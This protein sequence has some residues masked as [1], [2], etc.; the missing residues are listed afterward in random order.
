MIELPGEEDVGSTFTSVGGGG[1]VGVTVIGV[2]V[3]QAV[4]M[5]NANKLLNRELGNFFMGSNWTP[6]NFN[7]QD[8][9][10]GLI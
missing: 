4:N 3:A 1:G 5:N 7:T 2:A 8:G 10:F 9:S 6:S